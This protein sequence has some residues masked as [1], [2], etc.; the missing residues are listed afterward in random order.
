MIFIYGANKKQKSNSLNINKYVNKWAVTYSVNEDGKVSLV[1]WKTDGIIVKAATAGDNEASINL[2]I[3]STVNRVPAFQLIDSNSRL[4]PQF[5]DVDERLDRTTNTFKHT[6]TF[7]D[8]EF[9]R[10]EYAASSI[11]TIEEFFEEMIPSFQALLNDI[12]GYV[13]KISNEVA[14]GTKTI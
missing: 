3:D 6:N 10:R 7:K 13:S 2:T 12:R 8:T 1:A 5:V 4:N 9:Y 11:L 14:S